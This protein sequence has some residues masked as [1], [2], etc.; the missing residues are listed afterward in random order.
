MEQKISVDISTEKLEDTNNSPPQKRAKCQPKENLPPL[1]ATSINAAETNDSLMGTNHLLNQQPKNSVDA[2]YQQ[3][4]RNG[5]FNFVLPSEE[6]CV[7]APEENLE[8]N[9]ASLKSSR[10]G[11]IWHKSL[12]ESHPAQVKEKSLLDHLVCSEETQKRF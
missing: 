12:E 9:S 7:L 10:T 3:P 8:P 2:D 5:I 4:S 1:E 6:D 11:G